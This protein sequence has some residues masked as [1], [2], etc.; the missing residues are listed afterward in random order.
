MIERESFFLAVFSIFSQFPFQFS[1]NVMLNRMIGMKVI[2][3][4]KNVIFQT[5][6]LLEHKK[7]GGG[8]A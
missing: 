2:F 5:E 1:Q 8:K 6:S 4:H 3:N 7:E